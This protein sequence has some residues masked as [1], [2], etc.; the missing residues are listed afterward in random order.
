MPSRAYKLLELEGGFARARDESPPFSLVYIADL[1]L[2]SYYHDKYVE[3]GRGCVF[4]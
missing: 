3:L 2:T 4:S 1:N